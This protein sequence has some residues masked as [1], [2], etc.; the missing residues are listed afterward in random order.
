MAKYYL[1]IGDNNQAERLRDCT[2]DQI[3]LAE[4]EAIEELKQQRAQGNEDTIVRVVEE[5]TRL[6]VYAVHKGN[7]GNLA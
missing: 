3:E 5:G 7:I 2:S 4:H 6:V 1:A